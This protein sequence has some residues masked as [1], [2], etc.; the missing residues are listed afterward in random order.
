MGLFLKFR[1]YLELL[2]LCVFVFDQK[3]SRHFDVSNTQQNLGVLGC[4]M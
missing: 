4:N 3:I 2:L 1:F